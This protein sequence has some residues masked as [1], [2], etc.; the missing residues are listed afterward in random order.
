MAVETGR[1][2]AVLTLV[3]LCA[4]LLGCN[5]GHRVNKVVETMSGGLSDRCADFM[6][7]AFPGAEIRFTK[8]DAAGTGIDTIVA[9]VEGVRK[10][11]PKEVPLASD[12]AVEC[13]FT[14]NVLTGFRWTAGPLH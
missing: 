9:H 13:Q 1:R 14:D 12:L 4:P 7:A 11:L 2:A 8:R 6:Q 5:L 10:N 3:T